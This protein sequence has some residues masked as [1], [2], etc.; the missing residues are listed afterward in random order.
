MRDPSIRTEFV[1]ANGLTFEVDMCGEGD[2]LALCLHGFP[3]CAFSWRYQLPLL[4]KLGYRAWAPN[5]RGYG[6]SSRPLEVADYAMKHLLADVAG[7]IDV[8]QTHATVLIGHDWGGAI[9]WF[10]ALKQVRSLER[11]VAL[12]IP[13]PL[14][15][16]QR[17][18]QF[19]QVLRSW[20]MF[21]F[22]IPQLPEWLFGLRG[23]K[24]IGDAFRDMAVHKDKFPDEVLEVYRQNAQQ[25]GA[26]KAMINYY[27]A[28]FQKH[29]SVSERQQLGK[30]LETPTLMIWGE[31]DTALGKEL[32][33][34]TEELVR[35][36]TLRYLPGV[37]HWVQQEAPDKVNAI[38]ETW[39]TGRPIPEEGSRK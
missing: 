21:F 3:E 25:P 8:S 30:V 17:A 9:A 34:G 31:E 19:P 28:L 32:T 11:L 12:N 5:L 22:Q 1:Q 39:L 10:F 33:Y 7:L 18:S 14:L 6:R 37:S 2:K 20:Y 16:F 15:F 38:M 13:H 4:A 36:L 24:A 35:D 29:L 26:L 23:A 27:R